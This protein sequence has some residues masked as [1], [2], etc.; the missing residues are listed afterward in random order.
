M[1]KNLLTQIPNFE[2][3]EDS[4]AFMEEHSAFDLV[5]AGLATIVPTPKF[6]RRRKR[7]KT[8]LKNKCVQIAF[9]DEKTLKDKFSS[10]ITTTHD[11]FVIN[12]DAS[13][14][15][16]SKSGA[17]ESEH[18]YV[19]YLNIGGIKIL[20]GRKKKNFTATP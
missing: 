9:K 3:D 10:L 7:K 4:A 20:N 16:L 15:L 12:T 14:I 18:F 8:L 11:F 19:P 13:G 17:L 5:D 6:V 1:K 2:S